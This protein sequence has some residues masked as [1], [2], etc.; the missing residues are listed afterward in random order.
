MN[1]RKIEKKD[2]NVVLEM[3]K[4]FYDSPAIIEKA[5]ESVLRKDIEDCI[6]ELPFIEGFVF[7]EEGKLLGY[8]MVAKSYS[9]EYGGICIWVED[10]YLLP[11]CR[12]KGIATKFFEHIES[13]YG[14]EAVRFRLE[15]AK[16]NENAIKSYEKSGYK[17]LDYAEM[18]K[19]MKKNKKSN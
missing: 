10:L 5:P 15:V 14:D 3:M 1:I 19:E 8:A 4:A 2:S 18:T 9:T 13:I 16:D 12:G 7:E 17:K 11:E 6:G